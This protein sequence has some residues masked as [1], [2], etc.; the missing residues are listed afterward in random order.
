[1][2][3][4]IAKSCDAKPAYNL[5]DELRKLTGII[6]YIYISTPY[7]DTKIGVRIFTVRLLDASGQRTRTGTNMHT[8]RSAVTNYPVGV[9]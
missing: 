4:M 6:Q 9:L 3:E 7:G 5:V 2:N 8:K 1:M